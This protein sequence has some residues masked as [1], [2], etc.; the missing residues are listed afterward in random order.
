MRAHE[1]KQEN[2]DEADQMDGLAKRLKAI[3]LDMDAARQ[4]AA[5]TYLEAAL[6]ETQPMLDEIITT[7]TAQATKA[8]ENACEDAADDAADR[9]YE[10]WR[11]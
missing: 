9:A 7:L 11:D 6:D 3:S 10:N 2:L 5:T 8:R 1:P 4:R